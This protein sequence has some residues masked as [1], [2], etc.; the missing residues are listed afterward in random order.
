MDSKWQL[1]IVEQMHAGA[2]EIFIFREVA[3]ARIEY[4]SN[5]S[6]IGGLEVTMAD[7]GAVMKPCMILEWGNQQFLQAITDG[8]FNFGIKPTQQPVLQN[9]LIA[10]KYHLS[11]V[12][13]MVAIVAGIKEGKHFGENKPEED[14]SGATC[15]PGG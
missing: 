12:R 15:R 4:I 1:R 6:G 3:G 9:E 8:L 14:R 7:Q 10:T 11:D 2:I 5:L 13:E